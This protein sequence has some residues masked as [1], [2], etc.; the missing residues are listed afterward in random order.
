MVV[1]SV[2]HQR[3]VPLLRRIPRRGWGDKAAIGLGERFAYNRNM[4]RLQD[5]L[6]L[7][8]YLSALANWRYTGY[9]DWNENAWEWARD[10]LGQRRQRQ[11]SRLMFEYVEAGG[12]IDQVPET[13][14]EWN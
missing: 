2:V 14:P 5:P 10:Q 13:R 8:Q 12:E 7:A 11:M 3:L 4:P 6:V 1:F 9:V